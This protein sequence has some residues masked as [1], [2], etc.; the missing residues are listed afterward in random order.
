MV[1]QNYRSLKQELNKDMVDAGTGIEN[2]NMK[3]KPNFLVL[4]LTERHILSFSFH[5]KYI[6]LLPFTPN[7]SFNRFTLFNW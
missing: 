2:K 3:L 7:L 1:Q 6:S 5:T 4:T